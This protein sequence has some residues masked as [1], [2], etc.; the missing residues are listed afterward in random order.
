MESNHASDTPANPD[1][2]EQLDQVT[3]FQSA[4]VSAEMEALDVRALLESSGLDAVLVG[5]TRYPNFPYE[6]R[7]PREQAQQAERLI[8]EALAAGPAAADEAEAATEKP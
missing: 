7:V 2:G 1:A 8:A 3:V 6:V 5:D 4:G